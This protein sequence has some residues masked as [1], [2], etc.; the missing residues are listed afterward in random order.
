MGSLGPCRKLLRTGSISHPLWME[1][2]ACGCDRTCSYGSDWGTFRDFL[3]LTIFYSSPR[4]TQSWHL[5]M[6][7]HL[8]PKHPNFP[9]VPLTS[10][11]GGS[12][13]DGQSWAEEWWQQRTPK[14]EEQL[15]TGTQHV[16]QDTKCLIKP[17]SPGWL[18]SFRDILWLAF[19]KREHDTST[20]LG[21]R[22]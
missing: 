7:L 19:S 20:S 13:T 5:Q 21:E 3:S 15:R 8:L 10:G 2:H 1:K 17:N 14:Q 16:Q 4:R 22:F 12:G 18:Q 11:F 6:Y 9:Q